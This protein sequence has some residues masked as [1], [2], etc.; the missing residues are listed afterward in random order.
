MAAPA[1]RRGFSRFLMAYHCRTM[2]NPRQAVRKVSSIR[3]RLRCALRAWPDLEGHGNQ[4]LR[5]ASDRATPSPPGTGST[6]SLRVSG[7]APELPSTMLHN[8]GETD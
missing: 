8:G 7:A 5:Y 1:G 4:E 6:S 3:P 2:G